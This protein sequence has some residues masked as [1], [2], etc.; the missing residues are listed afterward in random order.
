LIDLCDQAIDAFTAARGA[1]IWEHRAIGLG[2]IPGK[3]RYETLKRAGFRCELCG[4]PASERAL[5]VD[6]IIPR[7]AGGQDA[8]E[9]FQALCWL[10]NTNKGAGDATDFREL[11]KVLTERSQGCVFCEIP[12]TR[13]VA[14]NALAFAIR[15]G[16]PVTPLHT[17]VLPKRHV[18]DYFD[19]FSSEQKAIERLLAE[20]RNAIREQDPTVVA[21]NLGVNAGAA[22]GQTI[23]HAHV[24]LIP[25]RDGD[26][27]N[28]RGGVRA[29][30]PGKADY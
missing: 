17:L 18:S 3:L 26:V 20:C 5:D 16:F 4:I 24:H 19:L 6:H 7:K 8:P 29:V 23:F 22:A 21:F 10:C 14:E 12:Q 13:I 28:P 15:D 30:I 11:P 25:R 9:N 1:A 27:P 2:Q